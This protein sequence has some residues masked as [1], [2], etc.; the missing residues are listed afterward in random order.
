MS[1]AHV[2]VTSFIG[3]EAISRLYRFDVGVVSPLP[4]EVLEVLVLGKRG[5][6]ATQIGGKS[7]SVRGVV[8]AIRAD[9]TREVGDRERR[10]AGG[11]PHGW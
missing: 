9:G 3:T 8:T 2:R 5:V 7:R 4:L 1:G 11:G 10:G 6:L